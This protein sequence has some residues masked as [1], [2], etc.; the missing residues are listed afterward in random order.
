MEHFTN[1]FD[2]KNLFFVFLFIMASF[3]SACKKEDANSESTYLRVINEAPN[4]GTYNVYLNNSII[5][6]AALPFGGSI[7]YGPRDAGSYTLK[8]TTAN[9]IESLL[10][11]TITL[12]KN[13]Y[14]SFYLTG[15]VNALESL[16]LTDDLSVP[17]AD[18]AYIRFINL[19]PDAAALDL[20][21]TGGTVLFT[22]RNYKTASGFIAI[23]PG[24]YDLD[25]KDASG[26]VKKTLTGATFILGFHHD[27]ICNGLLNPSNDTEK[28]LNLQVLTIK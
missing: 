6:T 21:K 17:A 8:F 4:I 12:N 28:A 26:T 18:K 11:S 19:A 15:K 13:A 1:Q 27:I 10:T 25:I 20:T 7:A 24:T 23:E 14:H 16:L 2:K 22:N 5:N 3:L 9:T